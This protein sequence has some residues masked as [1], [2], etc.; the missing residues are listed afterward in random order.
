MS[1][2]DN[3]SVD[4]PEWFALY[5]RPR[6]EKH[7]A[8]T[9]NGRGIEAYCPVQ[10]VVRQWSDRKKLIIE[11]VFRNYVFARV[12]KP[13]HWEVRETDG[14]INFVHW[15]GKPAVVRDSEIETIK[16]FL[17]DYEDISVASSALQADQRVKIVSGIFIDRE[18]VVKQVFG[19]KVKIHIESLGVVLQA[20]VPS[21][22]V[23][24]MDNQDPE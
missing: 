20:T 7:V 12:E 4:T 10:K 17:N 13:R 9:L 14:V 19:N 18:A 5:T 22:S 6:S 3:S 16:R 2:F 23:S 15:Q 8:R 1:T 21:G 24:A 11:P